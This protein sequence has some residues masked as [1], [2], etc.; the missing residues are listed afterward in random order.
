[1][2]LESER[3]FLP[4][5]LLSQCSREMTLMVGVALTDYISAWS[6]VDVRGFRPKEFSSWGQSPTPSCC[7]NEKGNEAR[8]MASGDPFGFNPGPYESKSSFGLH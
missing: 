1:M 8:V 7:I 5:R 2:S 3:G 6:L 4:G